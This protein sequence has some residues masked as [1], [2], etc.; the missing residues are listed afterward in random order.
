[1]PVKKMDEDLLLDRLTGV[2]R[3]H[4]YTGSSLS[5]ISKATGLQ[6]ASLY[7]RFPGGKEEM[8]EAVMHRAD[9]WF[10]SH[11]LA[12]LTGPGDPAARV[13]EMANRLSEFYGAGKNSCLL[14]S[15]SLGYEDGAI[16]EHIKQSLNA[17]VGAMTRIAKAAGLGPA[18]AK[19]KAEEALIQIQGA[20]VMARATGDTKP[21]IRVLKN[22]PELLTHN[23]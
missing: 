6:R 1:M 19:Q 20:L 2:F 17:W 13:Q 23:S 10:G 16:R 9:E 11:I 12:P 3:V 5:L 7:H 21:F 8:A 18:N 15:L 4:G 22:L 14:D